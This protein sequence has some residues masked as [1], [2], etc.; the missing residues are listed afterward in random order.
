MILPS[1][2]DEHFIKPHSPKADERCTLSAGPVTK[3]GSA[4]HHAGEPLKLGVVGG[5]VSAGHGVI[6][7]PPS[8]YPYRLDGGSSGWRS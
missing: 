3:S 8:M 2:F 7:G 1:S 4:P 5:S 6:D